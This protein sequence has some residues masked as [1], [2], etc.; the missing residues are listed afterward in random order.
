MKFTWILI[1][2]WIF[3]RNVRQQ[4]LGVLYVLT[5]CETPYVKVFLES[6]SF[7]FSELSAYLITIL[8]VPYISTRGGVQSVRQISN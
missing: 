4:H 8:Q 6:D 3:I 1:H 7:A 5:Q 2:T